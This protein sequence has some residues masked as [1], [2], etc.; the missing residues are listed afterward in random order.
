MLNIPL[1]TYADSLMA[2]S[3]SSSATSCVQYQTSSD[4][5]CTISVCDYIL[6]RGFL[7]VY[8]LIVS[9]CS[10]KLKWLCDSS[11][12][13]LQHSFTSLRRAEETGWSLLL[14]SISSHTE[15]GLKRWYGSKN[16]ASFIFSWLLPSQLRMTALLRSTQ[17]VTFLIANRSDSE[18]CSNGHRWSREGEM[19]HSKVSRSGASSF[20]TTI[21]HCK[22]NL[23]SVWL[24]GDC[25]SFS[26]PIQSWSRPRKDR[27][28]NCWLTQ[29]PIS[30]WSTTTDSVLSH[31]WWDH[32]LILYC[33]LWSCSTP[34]I[35]AAAPVQLLWT[36]HF[37]CIIFILS[38]LN[39][40]CNHFII[41][42]FTFS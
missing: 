40:P 18:R 12:G 1:T 11:W 21:Q 33:Q 30:C 13:C 5:P 38:L 19:R 15:R 24:T 9:S 14:L 35:T 42:I 4:T 7:P 10:L 25:T 22:S 31:Y 26:V 3:E 8:M 6:T 27:L 17:L 29:C 32:L 2:V 37:S 39:Q 28:L 34:L 16:T 20:K 41:V 36:I 23:L